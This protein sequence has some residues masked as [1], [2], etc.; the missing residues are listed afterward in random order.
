MNGSKLI[1]LTNVTE[2]AFVPYQNSSSVTTT[3]SSS[4]SS[5]TT[6]SSLSLPSSDSVHA[7]AAAL[8]LEV[9]ATNPV[10]AL[11]SVINSIVG[12]VASEK[13][14]TT[15]SLETPTP[16]T[17]SIFGQIASVGVENGSSIISSESSTV[18]SSSPVDVTALPSVSEDISEANSVKKVPKDSNFSLKFI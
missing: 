15:I 5:N 16:T 6:A 8:K 2:S 11:S 9:G 4:S 1:T 17:V 14:E 7:V 12:G 10:G 3:A 18:A 13:V